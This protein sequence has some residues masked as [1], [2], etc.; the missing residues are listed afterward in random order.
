[1]ILLSDIDFSLPFTN[2]VIIFSLVLFI[3][4][5]SPILLERIK[6]PHIIGLII[7]GVIVG[8][9]GLNLLQRD[10]SIV[11]FGTVGLLYIMFLAGLEIDMEEFKK[12]TTKSFLLGIYAFIIPMIIGYV[13]SIYLM[14]YPVLTS[15]LLAS[16][17]AS[18]TLVTYPIV[19]KYGLANNRAVTITVGATM[20]TD[21]L[22]L[23]VLAVVV[24]MSQGTVTSAFWTRLGISV[25]VMA[26]IIVFVFPLIA[27]WFFKKIEDGISQY[28]FVL[29]M[30]FL[31]GFLAELAG[32]EAI[33]GAF[34]AGLA[35]NKFIPHNSALMNRIGFVGNAIFIPFFLVGVGMLVDIKAAFSSWKTVEVAGI[36]IGGAL[37]GKWLSCFLAQ[38][39]FKLTNTE[40]LMIYGLS[41]AQAAAT[42]ATVLVGYNVILGETPEGAPIRL[43]DENIL[44]GSI[45]LILVSC[46]ISSFLVEKASKK[47]VQEEASGAND[48]EA[49]TDKTLISINDPEKINSLVELG[50]LITQKKKQEKLLAVHVVEAQKDDPTIRKASEKMLNGVE[51]QGAGSDVTIQTITRFDRNVPNGILFTSKEHQITDIILGVTD[52]S[53]KKAGA[54]TEAILSHTEETVYVYRSTQPI[55]TLKRVVVVVNKHAELEEGFT[56]WVKKLFVLSQESGLPLTFYAEPNTEESIR[57]INKN[58]KKPLTLTYVTFDDWDEFLIVG[59]GLSPNDLLIIVSSRKGHLSYYKKLDKIPNYIQRYFAQNST[60]ILYPQQIISYSKLSDLQHEEGNL[61]DLFA[62]SGKLMAK[63]AGGLLGRFF[64]NK[65]LQL[66]PEDQKR[67]A[68]KKESLKAEEKEDSDA[69]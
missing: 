66:S 56:H 60:L 62:E 38:K 59:K 19:S 18:H 44:N 16:T 50:L 61:L 34:L 36:M 43:L 1:M 22:T 57:T 4:L 23:L 63:K 5:F 29:A 41:T 65:K 11:L 20:V 64:G 7:A 27:R 24:G 51:Q 15:I 8:P 55:N 2:P 35:L 26:L 46:T 32:I 45:L 53:K 9:H 33:I 25:A 48:E 39:T 69:E 17:F 12:N 37:I 13:V 21:I 30:V 49:S 31:G 47:M 68:R 28:I 14:G 6:V 3:I 52:S 40:G 67:I 54:T 58:Q 10:S 42:L